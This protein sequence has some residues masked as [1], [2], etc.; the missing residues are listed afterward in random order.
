MLQT[1]SVHIRVG[2]RLLVFYI[3]IMATAVRCYYLSTFNPLRTEFFKKYGNALCFDSEISQVIEI[4]CHE[5]IFILH[6]LVFLPENS[7]VSTSSDMDQLSTNWAQAKRK[8]VIQRNVFEH[9]VCKITH[10]YPSLEWVKLKVILVYVIIIFDRNWTLIYFFKESVMLIRLFLFIGSLNH[11][12]LHRTWCLVGALGNLFD[13]IKNE[14]ILMY[15]KRIHIIA[16]CY[17]LKYGYMYAHK[18]MD[19]Y[20]YMHISSK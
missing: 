15:Q 5:N 12:C 11:T 20:I 10:I 18:H 13:G 1:V 19:I 14:R 3:R 6:S 2:K 17:T 9:A 4:R 7:G 16:M 8:L